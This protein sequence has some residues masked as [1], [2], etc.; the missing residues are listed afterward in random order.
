MILHKNFAFENTIINDK[1]YRFLRGKTMKKTLLSGAVT[2]SLGGIVAKILGALYRVPLTNVIGA[3]ALGLYQMIFPFYTMLLTFSST[4]VPNGIAK[5][6]AEGNSP[7]ATLKT[8]LKTFTVSGLIGTLLMA[9]FSLPLATFQGNE[10]AWLSYLLL[11]PSILVVSVISCYRGYYQGKFNMK[12]TALSQILEQ[13]V[14]LGFGLV[15]TLLVKGSAT[16]VAGLVAL[17]V[18][19]SELATLLYFYILSKKGGIFREKSQETVNRKVILKAVL[20]ISLTS[21]V[22]PVLRAVDSVLILNIVGAY[23][24]DVTNLYGVYSGAV[25]SLVGV[26]VALCYSVAVA[27]VPIVASSKSYQKSVY[28]SFA[29]TLVLSATAGVITFFSA[30]LLVKILYSG[31]ELTYQNV[32]IKM[33]K[34]SAISIILLPLVQTLNATL[35]AKSKYKVTITSLAVAGV[36]KIIFSIFLYKFQKIGIYG[37]I[38]SDILC[39]F[40]ACLIN[41]GY[42]IYTSINSK[43]NFENVRNNGNRLRGRR[44]GLVAPR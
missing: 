41:L 5:I 14:K 16:L 32:A 18:T 43:R 33:L 2:L 34:I 6:I 35:N 23:R 3:E 10:K 1:I 39:Y 44:K 9:L 13:V 4:G 19:L 22:I 17:A 40:L 11:S 38:Y 24:V 31:L 26:P 15:L 42:I 7:S 12:P 21:L 30:P 36:L 37:A 29:L 28:K 27:S 25:E 20:P 8:A